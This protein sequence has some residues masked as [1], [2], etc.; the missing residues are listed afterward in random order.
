MEKENIDLIKE[1]MIRYFSVHELADML[2][3]H[4]S[5][6]ELI[7]NLTAINEGR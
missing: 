7:D 2:I 1:N 6:D 4:M 3:E 5:E